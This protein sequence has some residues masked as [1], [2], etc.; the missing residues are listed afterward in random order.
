M[1][2]SSELVTVLSKIASNSGLL[3][4]L[5]PFVSYELIVTAD[6]KVS[7][8]VPDVSGGSASIRTTT[9]EGGKILMR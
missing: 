1:P 9:L 5:T 2:P 6:N 7:R 8:G 3:N 4:D